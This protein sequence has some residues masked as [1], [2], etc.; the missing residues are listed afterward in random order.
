MQRQEV[1][2]IHRETGKK[3]TLII[4]E[5]KMASDSKININ[6][7][8]L[9]VNDLDSYLLK[10]DLLEKFKEEQVLKHLVVPLF[11]VGSKLYVSMANP[12]DIEA[13][14]MIGFASGYTQ[15]RNIEASPN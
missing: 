13:Q 8:Q 1:M 2:R 9:Q 12:K 5:K 15:I 4:Y 6:L 10:G 3:V 11:A 7:A 14:Q